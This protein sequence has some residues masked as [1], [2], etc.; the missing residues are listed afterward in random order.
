MPSP[1]V[2]AEVGRSLWKKDDAMLMEHCEL[3]DGLLFLVEDKKLLPRYTTAIVSK[4]T[5]F[6]VG[7]G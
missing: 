2:M 7:N 3:I 5:L 4:R 1:R 6:C